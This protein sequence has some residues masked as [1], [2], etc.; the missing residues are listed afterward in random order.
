[1]QVS[2]GWLLEY[3]PFSFEDGLR[4]LRAGPSNAGEV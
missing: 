1:M 4:L 3:E 2:L